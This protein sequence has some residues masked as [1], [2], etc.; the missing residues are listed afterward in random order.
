MKQKDRVAFCFSKNFTTL[1]AFILRLLPLSFGSCLYPSALAFILRL[2]PLGYAFFQAIIIIVVARINRI[3]GRKFQ[4][5]KI[6]HMLHGIEIHIIQFYG[7][8]G[9]ISFFYGHISEPSTRSKAEFS[10]SGSHQ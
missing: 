2:L 5:R 1:S 6:R 8:N 4:I 10:L 9:H 3:T 7:C